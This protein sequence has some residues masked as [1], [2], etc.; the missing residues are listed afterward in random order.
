MVVVCTSPKPIKKKG[1]VIQT[2]DKSDILMP[3]GAQC[4]SC[5]TAAL[6]ERSKPQTQRKNEKLKMVLDPPEFGENPCLL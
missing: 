3:L 6:H 4:E 5:A 2:A 1:A